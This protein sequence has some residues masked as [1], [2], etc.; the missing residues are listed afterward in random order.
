VCRSVAYDPSPGFGD[1]GA[2]KRGVDEA[3]IRCGGGRAARPGSYRL[4]LKPA[5]AGII[6]GRRACTASMISALSIPWR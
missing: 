3:P 5:V 1:A 2:N 4:A 6:G